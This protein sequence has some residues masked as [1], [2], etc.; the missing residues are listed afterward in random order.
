MAQGA[1]VFQGGLATEQQRDLFQFALLHGQLNVVVNHDEALEIGQVLGEWQ[2][3]GHRAAEHPA[4]VAVALR[5]LE[6]LLAE[7]T[8]DLHEICT[9]LDHVDGTGAVGELAQAAGVGGKGDHLHENR[10]A[11]LG[12]RR[13]GRAFGQ[14]GADRLVQ[15]IERGTDMHQPFVHLQGAHIAGVEHG[16]GTHLDVVGTGCGVGDDTVGLEHANGPFGLAEHVVQPVLEDL[17]R[18]LGGEILWLILE[19][20]TAIDVVQVV[21]Q[22]QAKVGQGRV[23]GVEGIRGGAV[24][25]LGDQAEVLGTA[26]F[27]HA[28]H[29]AVFAA[30]ALHDLPDRVELAQ[31]AND[32]ALDALELGLDRAGVE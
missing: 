11:L 14:E 10:Q 8:V 30:H 20:T 17:H 1:H 9:L 21:R 7:E 27:K 12:Y 32:V 26:R 4:G 5:H 29:H 19:V 28:H 24:Q 31:L 2:A 25:F 16:I 13:R 6:A 23:T 18:L 3:V 22:H 15:A